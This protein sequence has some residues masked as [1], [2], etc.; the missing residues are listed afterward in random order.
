MTR[1]RRG[2][3]A[4]IPAAHHRALGQPRH[5]RGLIL[6]SSRTALLSNNQ[7]AH[8]CATLVVLALGEAT[9]YVSIR[10]LSFVPSPALMLN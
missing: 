4:P 2:Y 5:Y 9:F 7:L 1:Q 3:P 10:F 8:L 6:T